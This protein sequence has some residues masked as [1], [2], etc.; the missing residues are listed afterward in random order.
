M[1]ESVH[2]R[3][4]RYF[5]NRNFDAIPTDS[6]AVT[7]FG[8]FEA[9]H[10]YLINIIQLHH[11]YALDYDRYLEY[12]QLTMEQFARNNADK[13]ILL[14]IIITDEVDEIYDVFN[15]TPDLSEDFIDVNWLVDKDDE[16]LVIPKKQLKSV[17]RLEKDFRKL[18]RN[19]DTNYYALEQRAEAPYVTYGLIAINVMV[20]LFL[21]MSG[22]STDIDTLLWAGALKFDLV[23]EKHQ[24]YRLLNAMFLHIGIAHLFHNMFSLY[25]FGYRLEKFLHP[26]Q[27]LLIYLVSG[28][29]GSIFSLGAAAL[30]GVYPVAAGASG[31][32]YGLMG[33]LMFVTVIRRRHIEGI[34]TY[35]LWLFFVIGI[36]YSVMVPGI[37]IFAHIGG[38]AGGAIL[39]P[40]L[41]HGNRHRD[42]DH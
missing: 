21:E 30:T 23:V 1:S 20:W 3:F 39:T 28:F 26:V 11:G 42:T 25:I 17:L 5:Q 36:V 19:E 29:V 32:V 40:L 37:D 24:Y 31:A 41:L 4:Y 33:S 2:E 9:N 16:A 27:Y 38:F 35:I 12:K 8:T 22:S 10:L 34:T 13:T 18:L 14:N 15:Y 6:N 7:M